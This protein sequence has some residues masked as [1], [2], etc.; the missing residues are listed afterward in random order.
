MLKQLNFVITIPNYDMLSDENVFEIFKNTI[1]YSSN[2]K[3]IIIESD[4][5]H[6]EIWEI[7][8]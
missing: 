4:E 6:Q 1:S 3:Y 7:V 5:Y 2:K 8:D